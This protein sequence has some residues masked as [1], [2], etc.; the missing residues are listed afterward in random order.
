MLAI[1]NLMK[2]FITFFLLCESAW[3]S[4]GHNYSMDL[5]EY[6]DS[7][8]YCQYFSGEWDTNLSDE[9]KKEIEDGV[10]EYC[11]KAIEL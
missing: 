2:I 3:A 7:V 5:Q 10:N 8:G 4:G 6:I 11:T 1:R 9:H